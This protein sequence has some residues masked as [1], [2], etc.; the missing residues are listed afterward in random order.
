M[1]L[2][3]S[4]F[5]FI[6][7][8]GILVTVHEFGHFWVA[9][10]CGVKVLRFSVGFGKPLF[11]F[12]RENDP[13][14]YVIA[15]I[16][17]GGYV[18]MLDEREGAVEESEK[19]LAF[20]NKSL[21]SRSLIV[22]AG[23]VFN[24]VF[25]FF[26][27]WVILLVGEQ[28][29]KPVIGGFN[30]NGVA[31]HSGLEVGDEI[32]AVND[33]PALIWRVA[34]GLMASELLDA[35]EAEITVAKA[36]GQQHKI[37]LRFEPD[38]LPEPSEVVSRI[39]I[40]PLT[41]AIKPIIG[42]VI[43]G[44]PGSQAGLK[45]GDLIETVNNKDIK[46][47]REWVDLTRSNPNLPMAVQLLRNG[48]TI[49]LRVTPKEIVEND[50][51]IGRI[52]VSPFVDPNVTKDF[53]SMYSLGGFSAI[54]EAATQTLSYSLLTVKLIGRMI[55]GEASVQNLS[56]PI[57]LAQYAGK[58]ASTGLVPFLKFLAFV[59]VS[60]GVMNLLPIPML[61]GGHLFFYVIEAIKGKPISD[62][63][64][65]IFMRLGMF[66]LL[67]VMMLAVFIDVGRLIG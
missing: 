8:L 52:G 66:V 54:T 24:L 22:L 51:I 37:K 63:S 29:L 49:L 2:V 5:S 67:S 55:V 21:L 9:R 64:Q 28:G 40:E 57:S 26:A 10:K 60:L 13:T 7:A 12:K 30:E 58:T 16:P 48:E 11:K 44:D 43:D 35:G 27:F 65:A 19:H 14:E 39:G 45:Y 1:T 31:V 32:I 61:D 59:S 56:G 36:G 3:I 53:Y 62:K 42:D 20:N 50:A 25:A 34:V 46:T 17:L 18:K 41:P 4:I 15:G 6:L 33:R 47:W 38:N 23:P